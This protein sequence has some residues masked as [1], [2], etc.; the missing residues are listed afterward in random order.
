MTAQ[1]VSPS[2]ARLSRHGDFR[3]L[4][5]GQSSSR[6]GSAITAVALP[7]VAVGTLDASTMQVALLQ[8]AVWLPWLLIGLPAGVWVDRLPR[9]P[10]MITCDVAALL[11]FVSVPTAAWLHVLTIEHLLVVALLAGATT[12]FCETA[13]QVYLPSLLNA[14]QLTEGNAKLQGSE[15][16]AHV[17]GPG[18]AGLIAQL[19]GAVT[20]L[21]ADALSFL[22][23]TV[24][25]LAMDHREPRK[26]PPAPRKAILRDITEGL[27]FLVLDPYLRVMAAFGAAANLALVGYQA[28]WITFLVREN[29]IRA[30]TVG[31]IVAVMGS[32]GVIGAFLATTVAR[33]LGT[34]RGMLIC[35]TGTAPFALLLPLTGPGARLSLAVLGGIAVSTGVVASN[36]IKNSFRQTYT[37]RHLLSRVIT[38]MHLINYGTIPFGALLGGFLGTVLGL[39]PALW[40]MA[41]ALILSTG[42]QFLGPLRQHRDLPTMTE[43]L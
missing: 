36:I 12:V 15:A 37:P 17:A 14:D 22:I 7:L 24:C 42:I 6:L 30:G 23:S 35:Q 21:L 32:G 5:I 29:G 38:G 4:W 34:A 26:S 3:L 43:P 40:F 8:A 28:I 41:T 13:Y 20:G 19:F 2:P 9:R 33:R 1:T 18:A 25:L 10:I 31:V 11:L 16:V 27:R 39:R